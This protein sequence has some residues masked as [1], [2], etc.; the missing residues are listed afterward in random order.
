MDVPSLTQS[1]ASTRGALL[2]VQRYDVA[3]DL[4]G[5]L[6]GTAL[7]V[8][9]TIAFRCNEPGASSFV[10]CAVELQSAVLN[11][12]PIAGAAGP[13]LELAGLQADN[14]LV[15][16]SVQTDTGSRTAVHRS[17][18]PSDGLVYVWTSFEPDEAQRV[19]ACFD[20]PDLKAVWAFE[21]IAPADWT[22]LT[23]TGPVQVVD[24]DGGRRWVFADT[25][26]LSSYV[27]ALNAGPFHEVRR[28]LGGFDL[29]LQCRRSL[30][31]NLDRDIDELFAVTAAGL[32]FFGE[33]F[34]M[35]FPQR[36]YDQ[37]FVPDMGGAME[38]YGCVVW[39]DSFV[40]RTPP[41]YGERESRVQVLLHEMAH[42]WF[43]DMVTMRWWDDLWLNEAFAEWASHWAAVNATE[44]VDIWASF[45][46]GWKLGGYAADR[47]PSRHPIRQAAPDVATASA[48]FDSITYAKG[49]SVLKQLVA[50][51]GE[52]DFV[53]ALRAYFAK[54]TWGNATLDDLM[55]EIAAASGRDM[56]GWTR[57]WLETAGTDVLS[58]DGSTLHAVGPDGT[59]PR[60]HRV[61]VGVY[62]ESGGGFAL[63]QTVALE[64]A[65]AAVDLPATADDA[66]LLVNDGD[67][68]FAEVRPAAAAL[69]R[70]LAAAP[71]LPT[72]IARTVAV[73]TAWQRLVTGGLDA[74]TFVDCADRV[75][76]VESVDMVV[77]PL[78]RLAVQAAD[79]WSPDAARDDLLGRVAD[80]CL[81]LAQDPARRVAA[82]RALAETATT[83]RQLDALAEYADGDVDLG[84]RRLVRLAALGQVDLVELARLEAEDPDPDSWVRALTVRTAQ[85][86]PAAKSAAWDAVLSGT[87]VPLGSSSDVARAF[88]QRSQAEVLAPFGPRFVDAL[89]AMGAGGM[90]PAM[91]ASSVLFPRV[92]V[93]APFL[94][95]LVSALD[96][97][98]INPIVAHTVIER[99]DELRR[100][101]AARQ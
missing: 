46:A 101:L 50:Y 43:G 24:V 34:G 1:E 58:L 40:Y 13:R 86:D 94:D 53:A 16:T 82:V 20:Q 33:R 89:Q 70:L 22:V 26:P 18:D 29:G 64:I 68:T 15:V 36:R 67:L 48:G 65:A 76:E 88:W 62:R 5:L 75:L 31:A 17:V 21:V 85:P 19:W 71:A 28:E 97:P 9:S 47:A 84:W 6:E 92:G 41:S 78:L 45:L 79:L 30:A 35:P 54:H 44:Y 98:G 72:A 4:T 63:E 25:P 81:R 61:D 73:T 80:T 57:D 12:V 74:A 87:T 93:D 51:V 10:D 59:T 91:V 38:N 96:A 52:D 37:V 11:G 66:L 69:E 60:P 7:H 39:S 23:S 32:A 3:V 8:S 77:E 90:I 14:V 56:S 55:G 100:M 83:R 49:A 95:G 2:E 27:P 99:G 42:M